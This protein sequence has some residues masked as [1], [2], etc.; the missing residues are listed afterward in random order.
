M[1][2]SASCKPRES[3]SEWDTAT[4]AVLAGTQHL[5]GLDSNA[6]PEFLFVISIVF[7]RYLG[8]RVFLLYLICS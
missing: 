3:Q 8:A 4:V 7:L 5:K 2:L 1:I 6:Q